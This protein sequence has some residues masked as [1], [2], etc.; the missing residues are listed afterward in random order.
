MAL[1]PKPDFKL[2]EARWQ[3]F[4]LDN[5]IFKFDKNSKKKV[6]AID[7]PPP[8]VS[9][10]MHIGHALS[11]THFDVMGH[12]M[13]QC[14]FNVLQPI[15]FDDNGHPTER[16]V[17]KLYNVESKAMDKAEFNELVRKEIPKW[18]ETYKRDLIKL[19]H[20][21]D[22]D[23]TYS[24]I[25]PESTKLA[26]LS[27]LDLH[28][29]GLAYRKE[30]PTIWCVRCQTALSQ[31]DLEEKERET[32]LNYIDFTIN[33][34]KITVA[35]TRPEFLPACVG[36]FVHPDDKRYKKLVGKEATVPIFGQKV[37]IM[38]DEKVDP[39]FG[40]GIVMI[41]TFGDKTD[42]E[43]WRKYNL[44]LKIIITKDGKLNKLAGKYAGLLLE[45]ARKKILEE[46][47]EKGLLK[48]QEPIK[49]TVSVCWRCPTA[50]EFIVTKQWFIKLLENKKKFIE[51]GKKIKWHPD[52]FAKL[53]EN[54]VENL[55][56]DWL[57]SR[58]R[59]FG[60]QIPVWYC[61]KCG[62]EIL[63]EE[64][65]L[66]INPEKEK[67]KKK[68]SC[69]SNEFEPEHDVFDTWMTSSMTPQLVLGWDNKRFKAFPMTLRPSAR[70]II[71]TW[72]FY[73]I[74]KSWYHYKSLPWTNTLISGMVFD[75]H[76][77][78][79]HKSKG[80][81]VAPQDAVGK[82]GADS[83]RYWAVSSTIG[84]DLWYQEKELEHA[85][86]LLIKLWNVARF[87]E[88]WKISPNKKSSKN[89]IDSWIISR[90]SQVIKK[91]I[92]SFDNYDPVTAKRELEQFFW[93]EFCDFYMEMIKYRL[94]GKD[95]AA[96]EQAEQTLYQIF[97][98]VLRMFAPILTHLTEE[99]YQELFK[100]HE[101]AESIHLSGMPEAG[102]EDKD[103]LK[104]GELAVEAIAAIRKWK[105][106][107]KLSL[108][109]EVDKLTL[110][111]PKATDL[112]KVKSEIAATMRI[113]NLEIK[114]GE[115]KIL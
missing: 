49:Q 31:A 59:H 27:F 79:M 39:N 95:K 73:T 2:I 89:I 105:V 11:Y 18:E 9:G 104:L 101:K 42:I 43:W 98:G 35:T 16:F 44:P 38:T 52:H 23:I 48:K 21:Y 82:Y 80:N 110:Q 13:R 58:Q 5:K 102:K 88:L 68:C 74:V 67:P 87:V 29:K 37:P 51:L 40:T 28:K 76:G 33:K 114:K 25:S 72:E 107:R 12:Y 47:L 99:L 10:E 83:F 92:E 71:R 86:K 69:G 1:D 66:P 19:G 46:L 63:P 113:K 41:C 60:L 81:A 70:D 24:T 109:A 90:F 6:Y 65:D 111:H 14:G 93:Q 50:A 26:Q 94:Y 17:E 106:E 96:K 75:P 112:E 22:W 56:W 4:W 55:S 62:Q 20:G 15:G 84:S 53:Y 7:V 108:G 3:K 77:H 100:K 36:I 97:Y 91:Y 64:T 78:E 85:Q 115:L 103:A 45:E 30:E 54:W 61:K 34:E 8:T 57:I 32:K